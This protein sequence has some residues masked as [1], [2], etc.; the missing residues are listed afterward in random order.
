MSLCFMST[1]IKGFGPPSIILFIVTIPTNYNVNT[2]WFVSPAAAAALIH[3]W[4]LYVLL[5]APTDTNTHPFNLCPVHNCSSKDTSWKW[6]Q[7]DP[8]CAA[9]SVQSVALLLIYRINSVT[10]GDPGPEMNRSHIP[11]HD[12]PFGG[13]TETRICGGVVS[14]KWAQQT[15]VIEDLR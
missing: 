3:L 12:V 2:I 8:K 1:T 6:R 9:H 15:R 5:L 14:G 7:K 13:P 10:D 4:K 11:A